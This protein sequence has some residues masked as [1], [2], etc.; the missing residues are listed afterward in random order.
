MPFDQSVPQEVPVQEAMPANVSDEVSTHNS[1]DIVSEEKTQPTE[2]IDSGTSS[3]PRRQT[4]SGRQV[5]TPKK[6]NDFVLFNSLSKQTWFAPS[7]NL[8]KVSCEVLN[9]QYLS[10]LKWDNLLTSLQR[11]NY[12]SMLSYMQRQSSDGYI[13]EWHPSLLASKANAEDNPSWD[14]AGSK[15]TTKTTEK[16]V[17]EVVPPPTRPRPTNHIPLKETKLQKHLFPP[18][19]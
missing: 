12:G 16:K 19:P 18:N 2:S 1:P 4:R 6:L 11:G 10:S 5:K 3:P 13:E 8:P 9:R 14:D 17:V 15:T 7:R